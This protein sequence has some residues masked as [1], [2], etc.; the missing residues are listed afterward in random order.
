VEVLVVGR[1]GSNAPGIA[2]PR[3][4]SR[5]RGAAAVEFAILAPVLI[6]LIFGIIEWSIAYND[7]QG[8]HAAAREGARLGSL[9]TTTPGQ[10][11]TRVAEALDGV[12]VG[13][14]N[15]SIVPATACQ[16]SSTQ[17]VTVTITADHN[18][19]IP[20]WGNVTKTLTGK[21]VFRCE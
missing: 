19:D 14:Y 12:P 11:N 5:E 1:F 18:I 16:S 15:V 13:S 3:G 7:V 20:L 8:L 17:S 21:G 4:R 9:S 10:I 2:R 6:L